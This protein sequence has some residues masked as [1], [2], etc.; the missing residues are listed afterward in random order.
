MALTQRS[1]C[2]NVISY[3]LMR[4]YF[5][6]SFQHLK[7]VDNYVTSRFSETNEY[8][9]L[10]PTA[11]KFYRQSTITILSVVKLTV[12]NYYFREQTEIHWFMIQFLAERKKKKKTATFIDPAGFNF[13]QLENHAPPVWKGEETRVFQALLKQFS[14]AV[15][16]IFIFNFWP[17]EL[18]HLCDCPEDCSGCCCCSDVLG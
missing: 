13:E 14:V 2:V 4:A 16:Y 1:I 18:Y 7:I 3:Y 17:G 12:W 6:I 5:V 8:H 15:F 9:V 10:A 11:S